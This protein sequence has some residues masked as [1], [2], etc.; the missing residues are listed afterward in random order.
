MGRGVRFATSMVS[1]R[2]CARCDR[3]LSRQ[4]AASRVKYCARCEAAVKRE[5]SDAQHRARVAATYGLA[6]DGYDRLYLAQGGRCYI[7]RR[8]TGK[9]RRLAVD[10]DH[11]TGKVRGLLCKSCNTM[12]G[13]ARDDPAMFYR[14]ADYL[15]LPPA[16]VI[17][18]RN[19]PGREAEDK[20]GIE[21][22]RCGR[23]EDARPGAGLETMSL[24]FS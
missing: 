1:V 12:L 18:Y 20:R 7:C 15:E 24:P 4:R 21:L 14:A 13:H 10:H 19:Q 22:L 3:N 2:A 9:T 17:I 8:A 11:K 6:L 5:R 16:E 23:P